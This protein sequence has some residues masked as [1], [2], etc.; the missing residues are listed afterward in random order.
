M[1]TTTETVL[2]CVIIAMVSF[3]FGFG[4][5]LDGM[6]QSA[7]DHHAAHGEGTRFEWNQPIEPA[8]NAAP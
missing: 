7:I 5:S 1:K 4:I 3:F 6:R 2:L 8:T